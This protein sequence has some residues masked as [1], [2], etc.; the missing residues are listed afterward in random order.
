MFGAGF[1]FALG[2]F[3]A[4]VFISLLPFIIPIGAVLLII[5]IAI[6]VLLLFGKEIFQIVAF[7]VFVVVLTS[8]FGAIKKKILAK[9]PKSGIFIHKFLRI[10]CWSLVALGVLELIIVLI[11]KAF[12]RL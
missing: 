4:V 8:I 5:V 6:A 11:L 10:F 3:A 7:I 2:I 9:Y 12:N 1:L